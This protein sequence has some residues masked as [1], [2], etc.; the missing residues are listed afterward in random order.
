VHDPLIELATV[1]PVPLHPAVVAARAPLDRVV[2]DLLTIPDDALD[3]PWPWRPDDVGEIER[4]YGLYRIYEGFEA[5]VGAIEVGRSMTPSEPIRPAVPPLAAMMTSRWELRGLLAPLEAAAWD[6][7]PGGGEWTIRQAVGHIIGSQRSYGWYNAWYLHAGVREGEAVY[8]DEGFMPPEP[9]EEDEAAGTPAEVLARFDEVVDANAV[10]SAGLPDPA[11]SIRARWY[12]LP[13]TVDVRLGRYASHIREHTVQI[14]KTL[15]LLD[16]RPTETERLVRLILDT[17]GR[18]EAAL[19]GRSASELDRP[20]GG[21]RSAAS[22]LTTAVDDA[23][24]AASH[25]RGAVAG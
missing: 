4:R 11:M 24:G 1:T 22:I 13:V 17:Y 23:V 20:L 8:P 15:A 6:A 14:D 12:G 16:R 5:A 9:S 7:D 10:A 3:R 25:V 21:G 2:V 18:L 19:V